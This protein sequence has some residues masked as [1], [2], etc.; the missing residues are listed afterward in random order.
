MQ[1][2]AGQEPVASHPAARDYLRG[3][4]TSQHEHLSDQAKAILELAE[5]YGT[6]ATLR[7]MQRA[8]QFRLGTKGL[9][10]V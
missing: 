9:L 6:E 10:L 4:A 3:L 8:M 5:T 1:I 7:A 2:Y